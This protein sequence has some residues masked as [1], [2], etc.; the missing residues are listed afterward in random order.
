[1]WTLLFD[2]DIAHRGMVGEIATVL[3]RRMGYLPNAHLGLA[4]RTQHSG[5]FFWH[6][7]Q[8]RQCKWALNE[9]VDQLS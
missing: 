6:D 1:M 7:T 9:N 4:S 8:T 3:G 5:F 2:F